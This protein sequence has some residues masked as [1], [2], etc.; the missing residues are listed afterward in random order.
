MKV[1]FKMVDFELQNFKQKRTMSKLK[2]LVNFYCNFIV[3]FMHVCFKCIA[4]FP[5]VKCIAISL[6]ANVLSEP[7]QCSMTMLIL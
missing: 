2:T 6:G 4:K 1:V 5:L 7:R 3:I